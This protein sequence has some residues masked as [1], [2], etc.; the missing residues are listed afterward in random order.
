MAL[1]RPQ[2]DDGAAIRQ[3]LALAFDMLETGSAKVGDAD[4]IDGIDSLGFLK[5]A[6][7]AD[8]KVSFGTSTL[9]WPGGAA[10]C[11][12]LTVNHGLGT[13]PVVVLA[14]VGGGTTTRF[15]A[16]ETDTYGAT[17]FRVVADT[18]DAENPPNTTTTTV[19]WLA[20]G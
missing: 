14:T 10:R 16:I 17:T 13:T 8:R 6:T 20:V 18:I 12:P 3:A 11:T 9:A 15:P 4:K 2:S 1:P 5:L 19:V 7:V